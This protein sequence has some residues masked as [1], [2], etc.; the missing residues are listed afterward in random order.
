[1]KAL[2]VEFSSDAKADLLHIYDYIAQAADPLTSLNFIERLEQ[3]CLGLSHASHRGSLRSD[4][5]KHLRVVGFEKAVNV[6][7]TVEPERVVVLRLL[8]G[9]QNWQ[10]ALS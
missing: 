1:M 7:F 9:G 8:Y 3:F 5:R 2:K 10:T 4:I 6:A